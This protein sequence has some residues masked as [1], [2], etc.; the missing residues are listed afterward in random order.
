MEDSQENNKW[1]NFHE[2]VS[3]GILKGVSIEIPKGTPKEIPEGIPGDFF[4]ET[5]KK[6]IAREFSG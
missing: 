5:P 1:I 3:S 2:E 6:G 4:A